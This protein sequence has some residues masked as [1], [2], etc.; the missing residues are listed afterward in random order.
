MGHVLRSG[1]RLPAFMAVAIGLFIFSAAPA[2]A[3][4][5]PEGAAPIHPGTDPVR[6]TGEVNGSAAGPSECDGLFS[7]NVCS[8]F[9]LAAKATGQ[10]EVV[11]EP[12]VAALDEMLA[13]D[14]NLVVFDCGP[15][16]LVPLVGTP[17]NPQ[18]G[19]DMPVELSGS[20]R[21][22][23]SG[24]QGEAE[25]ITFQ[26]TAGNAYEVLT[27]P[28]T[29]GPAVYRGC[30]AYNGGCADPAL[31]E[32]PGPVPA[33]QFLNDCAPAGGGTG[34]TGSRHVTGGGYFRRP[35]DKKQQFSTKVNR[36]D[37]KLKG[38]LNFNDEV[39]NS[40]YASSHIT[41]AFFND[42]E[43]SVVYRGLARRKT[44]GS[45][46][47]YQEVRYCFSAR[48]RDGGKEGGPVDEFEVSFFPFNAADET[49]D[50]SPLGVEK[51]GGP[52]DKGQVKY[53]FQGDDERCRD[54][55]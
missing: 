25:R 6:W 36:K 52:L 10:I 28:F 39:T 12:A 18:A 14:L 43:K 8:S 20:G 37:S 54:D 40:R 2:L 21:P 49:C 34:S 24:N 46:G 22:P 23:G 11:V 17:A 33:T 47:K 50:T 19:C 26:A 5:N 55:D 7:T 42:S 35:N 31:T 3:V 16:E 30:A 13:I 48:A 1:K 38:V 44:K 53:H 32:E 15:I 51:Y 45:N 29:F 4:R 27:L 41:C 9:F